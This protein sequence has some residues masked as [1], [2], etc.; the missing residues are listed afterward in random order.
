MQEVTSKR[1]HVAANIAVIIAMALLSA[2]LV[3]Y[4]IIPKSDLPGVGRLQ[5]TNPTDSAIRTASAQVRKQIEP[6]T[7]LAIENIDWTKSPETLLLLVSTTCHFCSESAPFYQRLAQTHG[8]A[9]LV[10]LMPQSVSEGKKYL[11]DLKVNIEDIR[12]VNFGSLGVRGTPTLILVDADGVV[13][14]S[15]MGK[16]GPND[17]KEVMDTIEHGR[18]S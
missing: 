3:R 2:V 16:L 5:R 14:G 18:S 11:D 7:R 4:L 12:Q 1:I 6:G 10:V 9:Q 17:E 13:K 8:T 15:W